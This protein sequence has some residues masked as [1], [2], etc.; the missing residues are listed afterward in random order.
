[1][2]RPWL[3]VASLLATATVAFGTTEAVGV[4]QFTAM[5]VRIVTGEGTLVIEVDDPEVQVSLDGEELSITGAGLQ[6]VRLRPGQ[7]QFRAMKGDT[8]LLQELVTISRGDRAVV[9]V[10]REAPETA[11]V[12]PTEETHNRVPDITRASEHL[13]LGRFDDAAAEYCIALSNCGPEAAPGST[14]QTIVDQIV[15]SDELFERVTRLLPQ[16]INLWRDRGHFFAHQ[17]RWAEATHCYRTRLE[18]G[19]D[20]AG[21]WCLVAITLLAQDDIAGY[22]DLCEQMLAVFA[23]ETH[24]DELIFVTWATVVAPASVTDR[25][26]AFQL[27]ERALAAKPNSPW[28]LRNHTAWLYRLDR[29]E[30]V[31]EAWSKFSERGYEEYRLCFLAM[32]HYRL[33]NTQ[34]ARQ[35]ADEVQ[36]RKPQWSAS[37]QWPFR[38]EVETLQK[39]T[40]NV[41]SGPPDATAMPTTDDAHPPPDISGEANETPPA[42]DANGPPQ[43][44]ED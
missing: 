24:P 32:A 35:Y 29:L 39:E 18:L 41:L 14:R 6:E 26:K 12:T 11:A 22:R 2:R 16:D 42:G 30:E 43:P 28:A 31:I 44:V 7:Y 40:E 34:Q 3:V 1:S 13:R 23:D 21:L 36:Q 27:A 17:S 25:H 5:I 10:S 38:V 33:G 19:P 9:R 20:G 4:T 15:R 8:P 37:N